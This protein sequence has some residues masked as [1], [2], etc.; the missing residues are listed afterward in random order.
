[1]DGGMIFMVV[2]L[3]VIPLIVGLASVV[4]RNTTRDAFVNLGTITG[5]PMRD[6]VAT[7]GPPSSI[8]TV[9][10]GTLYQWIQV[11][12]GTHVHYAILADHEDRALHYTHQSVQ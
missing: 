4:M 12:Q 11:G 3:V 8:S 5:M 7:V 10:G 2:I 9:A 1:M 6:I